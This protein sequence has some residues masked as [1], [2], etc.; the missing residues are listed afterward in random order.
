M[1][2]TDHPE[3]TRQFGRIVFTRRDVHLFA[4]FGVNLNVKDPLHESITRSRLTGGTQIFK[5]S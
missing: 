3:E 1:L 2:S 5:Y 4:V